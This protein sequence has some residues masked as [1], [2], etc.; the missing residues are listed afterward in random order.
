MLRSLW[1]SES[2]HRHIAQLL[3][4]TFDAL[5]MKEYSFMVR[6]L[7]LHVSRLAAWMDLLSP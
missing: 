2:L 3:L 7:F 6:A 1:S 5:T 4:I